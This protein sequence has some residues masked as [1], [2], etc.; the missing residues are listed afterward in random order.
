MSAHPLKAPDSLV[1]V[2]EEVAR[3]LGQPRRF[4]LAEAVS[5]VSAIYTRGRDALELAS[6]REALWARL[7]FFLPRD[8]PKIMAPLM[9][10][11]DSEKLPR[12]PRWRVLDVGAGLGTTS[13]GVAAFAA[14]SG[15]AERLEVVAVDRDA[16][17]L[18][19]YRQLARRATEAGL[20]PLK[21]ETVAGDVAEALSVD[22]E[23]DLVVS[24][25][26][27]NELGDDDDPSALDARAQLLRE[28]AHKLAPGG[29]LIVVEPALRGVTRALMAVRDRLCADPRAPF[30]FG[31]CPH[32]DPCPMLPS[33][34]DW[35][36]EDRRFVLPEPLI[37]VARGAGLRFER[38]T[39]SYLTL[40]NDPAPLVGESFVRAVS[41][42]ITSKGKR[43]LLTCG[44]R[45]LEHLMRLD[46]HASEHN[47]AF[48]TLR[49]GD[50]FTTEDLVP[51]GSRIRIEDTSKVQLRVVR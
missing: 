12:G 39:F 4:D 44:P 26:T 50:L 29:A 25:L 48:E 15:A 31:P 28:L 38:S 45:G 30:V 11:A 49:R 47:E 36:H 18:Q 23:F 21:L 42:P 51:K 19:A 24:G 5:E 10:L 17:A 14:E 7:R 6:E 20:V 27:L 37:A 33:K 2:T 34:R 41:A 46:R 1:A 35:C 9:E 8:L 16:A 13:L 32:R 22:G 43:E 3:A 40:R